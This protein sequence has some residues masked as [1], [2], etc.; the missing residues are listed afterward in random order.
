VVA[1]LVLPQ[2]TDL[3]DEWGNSLNAGIMALNGDVE[4]LKVRSITAGEGLLGGGDLTQNRSLA[5]D[6]ANSG[7]VDGTKAVRA[8]DSRLSDAREPLAHSHDY[9][10][11]GH[12]HDW[13][14]ITSKPATFAP[15]A[16]TH[17]MGDVTGLATALAAKVNNDVAVG[18]GSGLLGGG[19]LVQDR[20]L[21]VDW[22]TAVGGR[23]SI[24][25]A[26]GT[27][28][29]VARADH[30]H[31]TYEWVP[32]S[33]TPTSDAGGF[34]DASFSG[35]YCRIHPQTIAFKCR[36]VIANAGS[37]GGAIYFSLPEPANNSGGT[38]AVFIWREMQAT[39]IIGWAQNDGGTSVAMLNYANASAI[40]SG[41]TF[42]ITGT[43][44]AFTV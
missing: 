31:P 21:A 14:S 44:E 2:P 7:Q 42:L 28:Q 9:A 38:G 19:T 36:L 24:A 33:G 43:Y 41:R 34:A 13:A 20:D 26:V 18:A 40:A 3:G 23:D 30:A 1:N 5:I 17:P 11:S 25:G 32:W 35:R 6:F 39:G 4:G 22:A 8:N 37:A 27:S 29:K 10:A 12:T 15:S 16:H